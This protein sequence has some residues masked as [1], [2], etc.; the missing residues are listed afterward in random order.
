MLRAFEQGLREREKMTKTRKQRVKIM[1]LG[2][3]RN[4]KRVTEFKV[5]R[6]WNFY[7]VAIMDL[8]LIS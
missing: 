8:I 2:S 5:F 6:K 1:R 4:F 3:F 7:E